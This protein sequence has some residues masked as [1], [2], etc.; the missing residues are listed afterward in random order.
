VKFEESLE[1]KDWRKSR[2]GG[3][4]RGKKKEKVIEPPHQLKNQTNI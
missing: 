4:G 1:N 3:G 2:K